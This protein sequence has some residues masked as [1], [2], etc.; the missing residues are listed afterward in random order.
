MNQSENDWVEFELETLDLNDKRLDKRAKLLVRAL[1]SKPNAS[2]PEFNEDWSSTKASYD[3]FKNEKVKASKILS[4]QRQATLKRMEEYP[5]VLGLQDT[6]EINLSHYP[7]TEG[8]GVLS[9]VYSQ[10]F[11]AHSTMVVSPEGLPLGLLAQENWAREKER[12][13][14]SEQRRELPIEEKE[15]YKWLNALSQSCAGLSKETR[16]LMVSDRESDI[17]EYFLHP[18]PNQVDLLLRSGQDRRIEQSDYLLWQNVGRG[19]AKGLLEID[20]DAKDGNPSRTARCEIRYQRVTVKPPKN[21][22]AYLPK[23]KS[24]GLWAILLEEVDAPIDVDPISWRLLTTI[25]ISSFDDACLM[26]EYYTRR[27]II[28]RFHFV[29]KSGC[30]IEHRR[31]ATVT[32]IKRFLALANIVAC[33][34]LYLT[35]S[36]RISPELPCTVALHDAEWHAL[37]GFIHKTQTLPPEPPTL[38]QAIRWIAQLGGFLDRKG[39]GPPGVKVLWKGWQRLA[40][41][42]HTWLI[43][44]PQPTS[45]A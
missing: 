2:I 40:D 23:L 43:F 14:Q 22:P 38:Q 8:T 7:K 26:V 1:N 29:L 35:Y 17:M 12:L 19:R 30:Q 32:A 34:L 44:N 13:G 27:W 33:R 37:Y 18:R 15:S 36:G 21:R 20:V 3:F 31:L 11:L 5:L 42:L 28:E 45:T 25:S 6:T 41:I 24:V 39:D 16:L 10:G 4:A 9:S